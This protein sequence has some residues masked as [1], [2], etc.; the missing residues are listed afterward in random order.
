MN[1]RRF[2]KF[3]SIAVIALYGA[4]TLSA[5]SALSTL[6]GPMILSY[7]ATPFSDS[8]QHG[9]KFLVNGQFTAIHPWSDPKVAHDLMQQLQNAGVMGVINDGTNWKADNEGL[10][11]CDRQVPLIE[12]ECARRGMKQTMIIRAQDN[13]PGQPVAPPYMDSIPMANRHAM[14]IWKEWAQK[15][16][17]VSYRDK[18]L[19]IIY[20]PV[21][22]T[23][24]KNYAE[25]PASDKDYLEKFSIGTCFGGGWGWELNETSADNTVRYIK[26][27]IDIPG[28]RGDWPERRIRMDAAQWEAS[29]KWGLQ[30]RDFCILSAFDDFEDGSFWIPSDTTECAIKYPEARYNIN[31]T[32]DHALF[33]NIVKKFSVALYEK[34]GRP[35]QN[36]H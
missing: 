23:F 15:P 31:P 2:M 27:C 35:K 34:T 20:E 24:L 7:I 13:L 36:A 12:A 19:L 11:Q 4:R 10:A 32:D 14:T 18:P 30:A 16:T 26:P 3:F 22:A 33:Y 1:Y 25:A 29:V 17:W 8:G 6:H 9:I 5:E 28:V 21:S